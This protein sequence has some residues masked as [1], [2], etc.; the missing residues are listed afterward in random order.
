[1]LPFPFSRGVVEDRGVFKNVKTQFDF[2][3]QLYQIPLNTSTT[4]SISSCVL[5]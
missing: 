4:F 5:K 1:M 2:G 3:L